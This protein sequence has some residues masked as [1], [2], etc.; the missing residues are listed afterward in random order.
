MNKHKNVRRLGVAWLLV[1]AGILTTGAAFA[2]EPAGKPSPNLAA[3]LQ[4]P[5]TPPSQSPADKPEGLSPQLLKE[6]ESLQSSQREI[7]LLQQQLEVEKVRAD[8]AKQRALAGE[9]TPYVLSLFGSGQRRQALLGVAGVGE[10][11]AKPG[12][13]LPGGWRVLTISDH[14]VHARQ[15]DGAN[16]PLPFYTP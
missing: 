1:G 12:D 9:G 10:V 7:W 5:A 13:V 4:P 16:V 11:R 3:E 14:A 8:L 2:V 6:L 15:S